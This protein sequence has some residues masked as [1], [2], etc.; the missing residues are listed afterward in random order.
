VH[1]QVLIWFSGFSLLILPVGQSIMVMATIMATLGLTG[2]LGNIAL[3]THLMQNASQELLGRVTSVGRLASFTACSI[4]PILGGVLVQEFGAQHAMSC[5]FFLTPFLLLLAAFTP[6]FSR[7][8]TSV[9]RH[10]A[11]V[12]TAQAA[13]QDRATAP[14]RAPR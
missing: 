6:P 9:G 14:K 4:G 12:A 11:G 8:F 1:I 7:V 13:D 3:D 2:A 5:L 10:A